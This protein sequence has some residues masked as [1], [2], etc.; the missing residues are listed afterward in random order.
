VRF[1]RQRRKQFT[2]AN[3]GKDTFA[4]NFNRRRNMTS[5]STFIDW[6]RNDLSRGLPCHMNDA[7]KKFLAYFKIRNEFCSLEVRD[8][9]HCNYEVNRAGCAII[10]RLIYIS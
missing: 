10:Y 7:L 4:E 8:F 2:W 9:K 6:G 5:E 3:L 1:K